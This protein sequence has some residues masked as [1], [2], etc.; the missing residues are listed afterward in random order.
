MPGTKCARLGSQGPDPDR[1]MLAEVI[2]AQAR[3]ASGRDCE[4]RSVSDMTDRRA[5]LRRSILLGR[6]P[7]A[8]EPD[9]VVVT[10]TAAADFHEP[11]PLLPL[12]EA[13]WVGRTGYGT[14]GGNACHGYLELDVA[15]L[16][17]ERLQRA[18]DLLV[19][20]H[21]MLRAVVGSDGLQRVLDSVGPYPLQ[22]LPPGTDPSLVRDELS[23][24]VTDTETWPLFDVRAAA[25][26]DNRWRLFISFDV[27]IADAQSFRILS[28][29]LVELYRDPELML[30]PVEVTFRDYVTT[31]QQQTAKA[32]TE[33]WGYWDERLPAVPHGPDIALAGAVDE[34]VAPRITRLEGRLS[35]EQWEG[36]QRAAG[37]ARV[38]PSTALLAAFSSVLALWSTRQE[39]FM[40]LTVF[41]RQPVH[42][43]IERVVGPFTSTTLV[44][45]G[46]RP[47]EGTAQY[48]ARLQRRTWEALEHRA[49]SGVELMRELS[50]RHG[51]DVQ[52]PYVYTFVDTDIED[53]RAELAQLG[54]IRYAVS[55]TPQVL[56]DCQV[57]RSG[58]ELL[59]WWDAV[60]EAYPPG[61]VNEMFQSFVAAARRLADPAAWEEDVVCQA[62]G[63]E[64]LRRSVEV[65]AP[66]PDELMSDA[67]LAGCQDHADEAA[68][69]TVQGEHTYGELARRVNDFSA[70]LHAAGVAAGD[71]V[72][73][74]LERGVMPVVAVLAIQACGA[75]YLPVERAWPDG[76]AAEV[77]RSARAG[78]VVSDRATEF[79]GVVTLRPGQEHGKAR[80]PVPAV[81][82]TPDDLAYVIYTSGSTG[83]PKGVEITH[84]AAMNTIRDVNRRWQIGPR[85]R[86]LGVSSIGFDLSVWDV[87][88]TLAAGGTLV[89]PQPGNAGKD[90]AE[91]LE[92]LVSER[93]TVWNSAPA[94]VQLLVDLAELRGVRLPHLRLAM[95]SGDW[96]PV[97]LPDRLRAIAP[98]CSV[99][100]LGGAT[101]ASIWS[102]AY[103][104]GDVPADWRSIPYGYPLD[105]QTMYVLA[106]T[107]QER[108][109]GVIGDLAIGGLG[110]ARGYR[111]APELTAE[112]FVT[113]PVH[114][115]LYFTGDLARR[116]PN[117]CL[118]FIGRADSQVKVQGHRVELAEIDTVLASNPEV[119]ASVTVVTGARDGHRQLL[120]AVEVDDDAITGDELRER[121]RTRLPDYMVPLKVRALAALPLTP[122]GKVDRNAVA[123]LVLEAGHALLETPVDGA[124][125]HV[126]SR[127]A[128]PVEQHVLRWVHEKLGRTDVGPRDNLLNAGLDSVDMLR[129]AALMEESL[130]FHPPHVAVARNPT[131]E[132]V[133]LLLEEHL[134]E[135][136]VAGER[137]AG[138]VEPS[139]SDGPGGTRERGV[140]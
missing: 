18:C 67:V 55:Q 69:V 101:E 91:W 9:P 102:V 56:I 134:L 74:D 93:V 7:Q 24:Q 140:V 58:D 89:V 8:E 87:F 116:L 77:V 82:T 38:T 16:D 44:E 15:D 99:V 29:E 21:P 137:L 73:V 1:P 28:S 115:R 3:C 11:F 83:T 96:I 130:G 13:Y 80:G 136:L 122:N 86:V 66:V 78:V 84:R 139:V 52:L 123:E 35:A 111:H 12:Q 30:D 10:E 41:D 45:V 27:L 68:L 33:A 126:A 85:D 63:V 109:V 81:E 100:S 34:L 54:E 120:S 106:P 70:V 90:P 61:V 20:R 60:G 127:T 88:G 79:E 133:R 135:R 104:V 132:T 57:A 124:A 117:G 49:V 119:R 2:L 108:P 46:R 37:Q 59:L 64:E 39:F 32:R 118:E 43:D 36:I 5:L 113:H 25:L 138:V 14:L 19:A 125:T 112:A 26:E 53:F 40:N 103:P 17:V 22:V 6:G 105:N 114:G 4:R 65:V 98:G 71:V 50:R 76:R 131:V 94:L 47:G 62:L 97:G 23:H 107:G 48:A 95:L 121:L 92:L 129:L 42:P 75:A 51:G 128:S 31:V 110:L 72:A